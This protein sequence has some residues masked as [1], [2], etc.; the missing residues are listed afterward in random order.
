MKPH[1]IHGYFEQ[2]LVVFL[3]LEGCKYTGV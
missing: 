1:K 3:T 2:M